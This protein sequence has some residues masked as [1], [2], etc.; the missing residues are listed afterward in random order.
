MVRVVGTIL[1]L[2]FLGSCVTVT[3]HGNDTQFERQYNNAILAYTDAIEQ[4]R[5]LRVYMTRSERQPN[6]QS[7]SPTH[8]CK[9]FV[10]PEIPAMPELPDIADD[11]SDT[12]IA[13]ILIVYVQD[14]YTLANEIV[15]ELETEYER[16]Q[17]ECG[18]I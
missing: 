17:T 12:E 2:F 18:I 8:P 16:Y 9:P 7:G 10:L 15:I 3:V 11:T 5:Q 14:I 1:S 6:R 13:H 4:H